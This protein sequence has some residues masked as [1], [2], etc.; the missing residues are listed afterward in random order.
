MTAP[1]VLYFRVPGIAAPQGSI[2]AFPTGNKTGKGK[3]VAI[4]HKNKRTKPWRKAVKDV[5]ETATEMHHGW[6]TLTV[7]TKVAI[8]F[9]LPRPKSVSKTRLFPMVKPDIDKLARAIL[10][11]LK[12][13]EVIKDD[14]LVCDLTCTKRYATELTPVGVE[15]I[16]RA[17]SEHE[18]E[19]I[20]SVLDRVAL[21]ELDAHL[22]EYAEEHGLFEESL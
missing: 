21:A 4:T 14:N 1:E 9:Y 22:S 6:S 18:L 2:S 3:K 17:L 20:R 15:V 12:D 5:A 19:V 10:D 7:P 11:A 13:A 16:V 8:E